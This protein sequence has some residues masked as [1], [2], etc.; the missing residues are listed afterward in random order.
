MSADQSTEQ[1]SN[2]GKRVAPP[3]PPRELDRP[4]I[5][6][7]GPLPEGASTVADLA[8]SESPFV[9]EPSSSPSSERSAADDAASQSETAATTSPRSQSLFSTPSRYSQTLPTPICYLIPDWDGFENQ[10]RIK[11]AKRLFQTFMGVDDLLRLEGRVIQGVSWFLYIT[12]GGWILSPVM[13]MVRLF[14][15]HALNL[16]VHGIEGFSGWIKGGE[17]YKRDLG[18]KFLNLLVNVFLWLPFK[19]LYLIVRMVTSPLDSA[20]AGFNSEYGCFVSGFLG[21]TSLFGSFILWTALFAAAGPFLA[22]IAPKVGLALLSSGHSA[23]LTHFSAPIFTY[24]TTHFGLAA[25]AVLQGCVAA[26]TGVLSVLGLNEA[27]RLLNGFFE[28]FE[29]LNTPSSTPKVSR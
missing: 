28:A 7:P 4:L 19:A 14:T 17:N 8:H 27:R 29:T 16:I 9:T 12:L 23:A 22:L 20:R 26:T 11:K 24:L 10:E 25:T 21:I 2:S 6:P 5:N 15:E 1:P 18:L 3:L 13:N